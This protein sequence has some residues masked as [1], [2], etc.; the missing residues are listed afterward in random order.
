MSQALSTIT[1]TP[2]SRLTTRSST[3]LPIKP[4]R[5]SSPC[6]DVPH[7]NTS[8]DAPITLSPISRRN[9]FGLGIAG[10]VLG[11]EFGEKNAWAAARR[12][13]P[14]PAGEK[15]DPNVSAVQA[16]IMASKKRKEA[17]KQAMAKQKEKGKKIQ[18]SSDNSPPPSQPKIEDSSDLPPPSQPS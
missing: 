12:P 10:A 16:K 8:L 17:M 7:Q 14:P 1:S 5:I 11:L 13:P 9:I 4:N 6:S 3:T 15:K 2:I 18:E